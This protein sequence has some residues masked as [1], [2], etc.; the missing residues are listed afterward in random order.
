MLLGWYIAVLVLVVWVGPHIH[1]RYKQH[2]F[3]PEIWSTLYGILFSLS[4]AISSLGL[5]LLG[6]HFGSAPFSD[7]T[8]I[9]LTLISMQLLSLYGI[10]P[11]IIAVSQRVMIHIVIFIIGISFLI[12]PATFNNISLCILC[13]SVSLRLS[14]R[15]DKKGAFA[16]FLFMMIFDV[17]AV[18]MSDIMGTMI[19]KYPQITPSGLMTF[20]LSYTEFLGAGDVLF[21]AIG[22]SLIQRKTS[23]S[24]AI[25]AIISILVFFI[26]LGQLREIGYFKLHFP[27]MILISPI[28]LFFLF[29]YPR[30]RSTT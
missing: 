14:Y 6:K 13:L 26:I 29:I 19:D 10:N 3:I 9:F 4:I 12:H 17:Y 22:V 11:V 25:L 7:A 27:C 20:A 30:L 24:N 2:N 18:W 8:Q 5:Y 28:T 21:S 15:I 16:I 1:K 23:T